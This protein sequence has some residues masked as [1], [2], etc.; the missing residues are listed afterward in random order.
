MTE[1]NHG[2]WKVTEIISIIIGIVCLSDW[3]KTKVWQTKQFVCKKVEYDTGYTKK[4]ILSYS[5]SDTLLFLLWS[6][7]CHNLIIYIERE[8]KIQG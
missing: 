1:T 6:K 7:G 4:N 3:T 8:T 5:C 2:W